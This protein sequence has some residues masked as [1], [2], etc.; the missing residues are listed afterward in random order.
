LG[1]FGVES[2]PLFEEA[3]ALAVDQQSGDLLVIDRAAGTLSRFHE[4]GTVSNF[5]ALGVNVISGF[6]FGNFVDPGEV[7][8]AVDSSGG[9]TD[10]DI[11]VTEPGTSAK[12][13]DIFDRNGNSVGQLT[14]SSEGSFNEPC[15]V[16]VDSLGNVYVGDF[17]GKIHKFENPPVDGESTELSFSQDCTLAA[18]DGP[19]DS[20]IFPPQAPKNT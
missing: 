7:Q 9:A 18:G 11:Y 19:T 6:D 8:V 13:V 12:S 1:N 17:S 16:S 15:G 3:Q 2:E 20:F 4:D 10:G 5:S 14:E